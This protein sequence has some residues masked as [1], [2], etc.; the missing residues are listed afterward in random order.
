M[1]NRSNTDDPERR[2]PETYAG[3]EPREPEAHP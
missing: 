3:T 2:V 1:S